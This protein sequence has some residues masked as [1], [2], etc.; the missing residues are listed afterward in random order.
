MSDKKNFT[1]P[2]SGNRTT[3]FFLDLT[4]RGYLHCATLKALHNFIEKRAH[5]ATDMQLFLQ[6]DKHDIFKI[7]KIFKSK[8]KFT[9][10]QPFLG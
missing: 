3:F 6:N 7:L 4:N 8:M 9:P 5:K 10:D 1:R 2:I